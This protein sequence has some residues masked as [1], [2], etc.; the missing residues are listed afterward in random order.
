M[1]L[2]QW[3]LSFHA[4]ALVDAAAQDGSRAARDRGATPGDGEAVAGQLLADATD[5]GLLTDVTVDIAENGGVVRATVRAHVR[6]LVPLPGFANTVEGISEG[7]VER[8]VA[9]NNR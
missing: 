2:V 4:Q 1:G 6:T 7:P 8:F 9:E 3:G 5:S